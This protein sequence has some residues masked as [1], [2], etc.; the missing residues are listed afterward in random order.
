MKDLHTTE[1]HLS[2]SATREHTQPQMEDRLRVIQGKPRWSASL[3]IAAVIVAIIGMQVLPPSQ[4]AVH[5]PW[6]LPALEALLLASL[7]ANPKQI[8]RESPLRR[9]FIL[10]LIAVINLANAWWASWVMVGLLSGSQG[11]DGGALLVT[12]A[13]IWLTNVI[14]FAL[15]YWELEQNRPYPDFLFVQMENPAL[16]PPDWQPA[17]SDY[18]YLSFTNA[19]AFSPT[20]VLPLSRWA[21]LTM[22]FQ[23]AISISTIALVIARAVNTLN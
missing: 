16:A 17:F 7:V 4:V 2:P 11:Q 23:S 13:V 9:V 19:T 15:W 5:P 12:G 10:T 8:D 3:V 22:M 14:V 21:K 18:L 20:D 6:L 1:R